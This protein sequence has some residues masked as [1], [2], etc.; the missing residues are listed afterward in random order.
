M[1]F[2]DIPIQSTGSNTNPFATQTIYD[3]A[4]GN[5]QQIDNPFGY[6]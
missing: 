6:L 1:D 2:A 3:T 5:Q 4:L